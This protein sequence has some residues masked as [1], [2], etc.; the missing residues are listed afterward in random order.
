MKLVTLELSGTPELGILLGSDILIISKAARR[1]PS[2]ERIPRDMRSLLRASDGLDLAR[3]LLDTVQS[4]SSPIDDLRDIEAIVP[5]DE[6]VLLPPI[7]D[8]GLILSCGLN[9]HSHIEEMNAPT[10]PDPVAFV[11]SVAALTGS[12]T[13]I[14][15]PKDYPDMVDFEGELCVV[16]GRPC[17]RIERS[18]ALQYVAGY[19]M[20][21]DVSAR[22]W[23]VPQTLPNGVEV[24][25]DAAAFRNILGK[26]YPTFCPLGPAMIT[27]DELSNP[28]DLYYETILNGEVVQSVNTSDMV[29]DVPSLIS[30][31]SQFYGFLP[32]DV[33][34]T[35]SPAGA[36]FA[37]TPKL[38][39]RHG[40]RIE[41]RAGPIGALANTVVSSK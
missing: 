32:G 36:G 40:D 3:R 25:K 2:A 41:V 9:Y 31:F 27:A 19:T 17:H 16:I 14:V 20:A 38:F 8:P 30:Y 12:G 33:I 11:K 13:S 35:G 24:T 15:L 7:T 22:D 26:Q 39:M 21:N 37:R 28:N 29:F 10:F 4:G 34:T 23:L 1:L 5:F 6:A 18:E